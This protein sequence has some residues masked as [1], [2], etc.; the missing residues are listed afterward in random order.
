M[1]AAKKDEQK[2]MI[3]EEL[4][5]KQPDE[6]TIGWKSE[7]Q[8]EDVDINLSIER[9][10]QFMAGSKMFLNQRL[11]RISGTKLPAAEGRKYDFYFPQPFYKCDTTI[12]HLPA[13]FIPEVLPKS[14]AYSCEFGEYT[15]S[16]TYN[17]EKN[18]VVS[19]ASLELKS[20]IIPAARYAAV[21][22]FF[23]NVMSDETQKLIVKKN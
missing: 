7:A 4:G 20:H 2:I 1:I 3:V 19:I 8:K 5:F 11:N 18:E 12:Y 22:Q 21:K 10:P 13:N 16:Y 23:D 9:I 6:F 15:T 17:K 14:A